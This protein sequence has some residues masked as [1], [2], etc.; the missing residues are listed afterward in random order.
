MVA[1]TLPRG[2]GVFDS[3]RLAEGRERLAASYFSLGGSTW[4]LVLA[5]VLVVVVVIVIATSIGGGSKSPT[6]PR[7]PT[8]P[9]SANHGG[10]AGAPAPNTITV[11]VLN[12]TTTS[13]LAATIQARLTGRGYLKGQ[14]GNAPNQSLTSTTIGYATGQRRAADEVAHALG[15]MVAAVA[16]V[17]AATAAAA[18]TATSTP[19]VVVSL[20][21]DLAQ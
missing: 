1:P 12:G 15:L 18:S 16:P 3:E 4:K 13:G 11:A 2:G 8:T 10:A 9:T 17:D 7:T 14:V 6:P 5:A 20:G 21:S 19:Q